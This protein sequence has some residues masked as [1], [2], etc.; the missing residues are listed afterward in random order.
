MDVKLLIQ[1]NAC[2]FEYWFLI[3]V[4]IKKKYLKIV[5]IDMK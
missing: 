4:L 3:Y 2:K 5:K 1:R